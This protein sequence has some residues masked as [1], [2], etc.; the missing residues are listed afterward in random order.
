MDIPGQG[1][2]LYSFSTAR[3][4][5]VSALIVK[6]FCRPAGRGGEHN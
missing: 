6:K 1:Q 2:A 4:R 3:R 5:Q